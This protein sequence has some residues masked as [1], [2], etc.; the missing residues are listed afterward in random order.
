MD[1]SDL[2][3]AALFDALG[4]GG[5]P[6]GRNGRARAAYGLDEV[7]IGAPV[8]SP[9]TIRDFY[10]FEQHVRTAHRDRNRE[11]PEEWYQ[12]PVF[13]FSNPHVVFGPDQSIPHPAYSQELDYEL[14]VACV[15]GKKGM[16]IPVERAEDYILG[17]TIMNDWSARD[18]QRLETRVGL[19][20]AKSKDFA[21]SLGPWL[22]TP[23]ELTDCAMGRVGVYALEMKTRVNGVERSCGNWADIHYSFGEMIARASQDVTLYP[24]DVIGSGT[25]GTGC[26]LELTHGKGP[27]LQPGDIVE[28]EIERLGVL[29]TKIGNRRSAGV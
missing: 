7:T 25:V 12:F 10:A 15:I 28:L 8:P 1:L 20:P 11:V 6:A 9:V 14:E 27:W 16:D 29:R 21:T 24:G 13:Y 26:L 3:L 22:V 19:G 5:V 17:Y 4:K 18:I 23:D 2:D